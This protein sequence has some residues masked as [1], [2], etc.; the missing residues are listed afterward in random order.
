MH[1]IVG[2]TPYAEWQLL[3]PLLEHLGFRAPSNVLLE[4][5]ES[6]IR[7]ENGQR[8]YAANAELLAASRPAALID[9]AEHPDRLAHWLQTDDEVRVLVFHSRP[10]TALERALTGQESPRAALRSWLK[11]AEMI[12]GVY[13][14]AR[15]R[16]MLVSIESALESPNLFLKSL[17]ARLGI[18]KGPWCQP[19]P[20]PTGNTTD[21]IRLIAAHQVAQDAAAQALLNELEASSLPVG[22][23]YFPPVLDCDALWAQT[24]SLNSAQAQPQESIRDLETRLADRA[25]TQRPDQSLAPSEPQ[26]RELDEVKAEN[27]FLL[28]QLHEVQEELERCYLEDR[29]RVYDVSQSKDYKRVLGERDALL[30]SL[31]WRVTAPMRWLLRPFAGP[32][33]Q[34]SG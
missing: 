24:Q 8:Q 28:S 26:R 10:E 13:R 4:R 17:E 23:P 31:S 11:A 18:E 12:L 5:W 7:E 6:Q 1:L 27:D 25:Q 32:P 34:K 14:R 2:A 16:C 19:L 22:E 20:R 21:L 15:G 33:T 3:Q 9:V 29:S 30:N